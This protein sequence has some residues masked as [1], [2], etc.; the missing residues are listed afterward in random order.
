MTYHARPV[1]GCGPDCLLCGQQLALGSTLEL[2]ELVAC[3]R[4]EKRFPASVETH[5]LSMSE[6]SA[7]KLVQLSQFPPVE[8][9]RPRV[10]WIRY[11]EPLGHLDDLANRLRCFF[12]EEAARTAIGV[13]PFD[14]PLMDRLSSRGFACAELPISASMSDAT[15]GYPYLETIQQ[16][17]R[18]DFLAALAS[19]HG[20]ADVVSCR[21]LLEHS[22]D[23][24]AALAGLRHLMKENGFLLIEIPDSTKFLSSLD[25][26]FI[27]E[28]HIC[29]FTATTFQ[30]CALRAG[31]EVA[32][33]YRYEGVL[34]DALIFILRPRELSQAKT[35]LIEQH[36]HSPSFTR[37]QRGFENIR[38]QYLYSLKKLNSEGCNVAIFGAGHQSIMFINALRLQQY[39]TVAVDDDPAKAG[40]LIPGTTIEIFPSAH[41]M[42]DQSIG[43]CLLGV[44]PAAE[45]KVRTKCA[46]YLSRGGRMHTI[47]PGGDSGTL[48]DGASWAS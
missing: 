1:E 45:E 29:Y 26:S 34:E 32:G 20:T 28:E 47:F 4:F 30:A 35:N 46:A 8:F 42:H 6:C 25:Y 13:G 19:E 16:S 33:F 2:G 40:Y 22:H 17:L 27:W 37:Y 3:N 15:G 14:T 31:Y 10:P 21:Y 44:G 43:V 23:P 11:N 12:P 36:D 48:I 9:V 18:P 24:V 41:L 39:F 5:P 7:C 38:H